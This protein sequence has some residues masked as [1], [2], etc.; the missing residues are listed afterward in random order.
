VTD[1]TKPRPGDKVR[2][3]L[4]TVDGVLVA[5]D[6]QGVQLRL[7]DGSIHHLPGADIHV[8]ERADDRQAQQQPRRRTFPYEVREW[9]DEEARVECFSGRD[10]GYVVHEGVAIGMTEAPTV[11]VQKD[12]GQIVSWVIG[13]TR[14]AQSDIAR[15]PAQREPRVFRSDGPEPPR[16]V[17]AVEWLEVE[18]QYPYLIRVFG[19][20]LW[21]QA[22]NRLTPDCNAT[23]NTWA[24]AVASCAGTYREVFTP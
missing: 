9:M 1:Y 17:A 16:D 7:D 12:D 13:L 5:A 14:R 6:G 8:L 11:R 3:T 15:P 21:S 18:S 19:G 2:A 22:A 20:W 10:P 4:P 23:P 24:G